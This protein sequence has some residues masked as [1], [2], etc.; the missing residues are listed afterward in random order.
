M[1]EKETCKYDQMMYD[2]YYGR[3]TGPVG[4][5]GGYN[6]YSRLVFVHFFRGHERL[7]ERFLWLRD[8]STTQPVF[9]P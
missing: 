3:G 4:G 2:D 6:S 8:F 9:W 5:G 7:L 1:W